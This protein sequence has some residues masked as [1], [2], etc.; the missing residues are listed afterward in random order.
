MRRLQH[1]D[2]LTVDPARVGLQAFSI[3]AMLF[4]VEHDLCLAVLLAGIAYGWLYKVT[5]NQWVPVATHAVTN[6]TL[7]AWV[8]YTDAW[9]YW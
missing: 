5:R 6:G 1:S 7:G 4:A 2:F 8:V 3:T 9:E